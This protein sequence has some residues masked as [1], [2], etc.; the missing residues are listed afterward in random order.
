LQDLQQK[1][2]PLGEQMGGTSGGNAAANAAAGAVASSLKLDAAALPPDIGQL[3]HRIADGSSAALRGAVRG[4]LGQR[5]QEDVVTQCRVMTNGRFPFDPTS[6][7]DLPLADFGK[8][9]GYNGVF[10]M[11]FRDTLADKVDTSR[12]PWRFRLDESGVSIGGTVPLERFEQAQRIREAYFRPGGQEPEVTFRLTPIELDEA[13]RRFT[14]EVDGQSIQDQHAAE[15]T[16]ALKWPGERRGPAQTLFEEFS[17]GRPSV[18][19][20]GEWA[21]F[22]LLRGPSAR[23]EAE[24]DVRYVITFESGG[25]RARLRLEAASIRNPFDPSIRALVEGFQCS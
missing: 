12:R 4:T 9:F 2:A 16:V 5:F 20:S 7:I 17:G 23:V 8:L 25:R 14:L 21:W 22:R 13:V 18:V 6:A 19:M 24:S 10:D 3:V 1:M 11:F 15:R